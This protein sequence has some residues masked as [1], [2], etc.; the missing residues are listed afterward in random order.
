M[1][2]Y[3]PAHSL[4]YI[5][6]NHPLAIV[7]TISNTDVWKIIEKTTATHVET[8]RRGWLQ[9]VIAFTGIGPINSVILSRAQIAVVIT[10][11]GTTADSETLRVKP[12][13]AILIETHTAEGRIRAPVEEAL[14]KLANLT[15]GNPTSRRTNIDDVEFI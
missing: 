9:S 1:A 12:E 5:E 15:Y 13:G 4:L 8:Q 6:A 11:L 7:D 14:S 10:D 2:I 3:A